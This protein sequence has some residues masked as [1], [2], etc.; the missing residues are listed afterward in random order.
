MSDET[1]GTHDV[2]VTRR[3]EASPERVWRAWSDPDEVRAWWGPHGFS[4]PVCRMDFREGGA[5]LVSMRSDQGWEIFNTWTYVS[6]EPISRI[7]FLNRFAD[8][9][10][11]VVAPGDLGMPPGIPA[12]VRHVVTLTPLGVTATELT[13]HE[14]GY[15]DEQTAAGSK[16]GME[17]CIDKMASRL[18]QDRLAE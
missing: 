4:S 12:E 11:N 16:V 6:I 5:T 15:T 17:E 7:E 13:V 9:E 8:A 3:L 2:V 10:G 14:F 18:G 1:Q